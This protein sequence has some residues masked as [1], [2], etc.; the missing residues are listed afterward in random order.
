MQSNS[1]ANLVRLANKPGT[2]AANEQYLLDLGPIDPVY[3][4]H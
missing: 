3:P 2:R 1:L 4:E